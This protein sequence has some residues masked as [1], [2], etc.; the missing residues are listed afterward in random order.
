MG[1]RNVP[2]PKAQ[3]PGMLMMRLTMGSWPILTWVGRRP[4]PEMITRFGGGYL[5][6]RMRA[7]GPPGGGAAANGS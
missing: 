6:I 2:R 5:P 4:R 7:T 3:A 1:D